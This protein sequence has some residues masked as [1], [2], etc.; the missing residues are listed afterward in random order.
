MNKLIINCSGVYFHFAIA[1]S[2]FAIIKKDYKA[3]DLMVIIK[4]CSCKMTTMKK[5]LLHQ[6][7]QFLLKL[8][9]SYQMFLKHLLVHC[10]IVIMMIE[11]F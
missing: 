11:I 1:L 10:V 9:N 6:N 8:W 2:P 3:L 7:S 4:F 5:D